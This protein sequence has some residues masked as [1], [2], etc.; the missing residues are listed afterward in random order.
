MNAIIGAG[1]AGISAAYHL[2]LKSKESIIFCRIAFPNILSLLTCPS[3]SS[4]FKTSS[5]RVRMRRKN[6]D[7]QDYQGHLLRYDLQGNSPCLCNSRLHNKNRHKTPLTRSRRQ[8]ITLLFL[9]SYHA[10]R[11]HSRG[12]Q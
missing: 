9:R 7:K 1:I 2:K 10:P 8:S 3:L 6:R 5:L 4:G 12:A 11:V